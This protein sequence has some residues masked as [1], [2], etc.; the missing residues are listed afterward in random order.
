MANCQVMHRSC[1]SKKAD[2]HV[3]DPVQFKII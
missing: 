3:G 2:K 1:N